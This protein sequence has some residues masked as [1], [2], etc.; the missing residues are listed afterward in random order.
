MENN[1][2]LKQYDTPFEA[3]PFYKIELSHILPAIKHG[4]AVEQSEIDAIVAN[5]DAPTFENTIE[6]L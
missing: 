1:P 2:F 6:A 3:I 5:G 4:I